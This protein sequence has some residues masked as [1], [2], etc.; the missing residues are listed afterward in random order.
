MITLNLPLELERAF[1]EVADEIGRSPDIIVAE[2]LTEYLE[3]IEDYHAAELVMRDYDPSTN[4]TLEQ[5]MARYAIDDRDRAP[6]A[7]A[8]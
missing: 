4:Q 3:D 6:S 1:T 8:A 7:K 2:A 5:V